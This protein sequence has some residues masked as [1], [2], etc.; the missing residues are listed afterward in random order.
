MHRPN[1]TLASGSRYRAELLER[2]RIPF[3]QQSPNVDETRAPSETPED[4]VMRLACAKAAAVAPAH[5]E[6]LIIGSDQAAIID[7]RVLGKPETPENAVEQ[8]LAASGKQVRFVTAVALRDT[9][10]GST[11]CRLVPFTVHFRDLSVQ[12][13]R[14]YVEADSP[15]DCAGSFRAEGYG[16]TL[17]RRLEGDDPTAL[18]GLP[19]LALCELLREAGVRLP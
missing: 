8:L 5:H 19:L 17:F 11:V 15:L 16:I 14:S 10:A 12:A 13:A 4:Y 1:L 6:E 9:R 2:L 18:V 7:D 3:R